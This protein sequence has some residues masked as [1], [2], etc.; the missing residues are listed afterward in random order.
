MHDSK[1]CAPILWPLSR[2]VTPMII[3]T[4]K[5]AMEEGHYAKQYHHIIA[6]ELIDPRIKFEED[7]VVSSRKTAYE[8]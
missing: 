6:T 1:V 5:Q 7:N 2:G 8:N 3:K 4:S